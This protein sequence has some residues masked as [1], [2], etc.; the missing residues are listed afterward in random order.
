MRVRNQADTVAIY[1]PAA[2]LREPVSTLR[3]MFD[4]LLSS[5]P[6]ARQ[7][8]AADIRSQ[9]RQTALGL[10]WA[11]II[12]LANSATWLFIQSAGILS[13]SGTRIPYPAYVLSGTLLWSIFMDAVNSPLQQTQAARAMLS[14]INF[15]RE[16]L[17]VSGL[18]QTLFNAAVK[19]LVMLGLLNLLGVHPGASICLLPI[20]IL[21]LILAG[22]TIGLALTPI[23][24]LYKDIGRGLPLLLQFLMYLSPIV[25]AIPKHG[26]AGTLMSWNPLTVLLTTARETV[27]GY[28]PVEALKFAMTNV[29]LLAL[30][31]AAWAIYRLSMPILI[32][33]M[34]S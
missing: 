19:L 8:M 28:W 21:S 16:A 26:W 10:L 22:T 7:L 1:E 9:Y 3:R 30:L 6:L 2:P 33:R 4:D 11:F 29:V 34:S 18:G 24:M 20:T 12:P 13:I 32:E 31:V 5:L 27:T 17:L 23:G 15:P 25:Y 14:K